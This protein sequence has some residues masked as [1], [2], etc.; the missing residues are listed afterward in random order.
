MSL[1]PR[2]YLR[3]ILAEANYLLQA[4]RDVTYEEFIGNG[5]LVRA[6]SR[7]IEIMGEAA[8]SVPADIIAAHPEIEWSGMARMRDRLIHGYF[9]VDER[10]VWAVV[11][12]KVPDLKQNLE[13]I[14]ADEDGG[15]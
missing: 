3:H 9:S 11:Q 14:L 12:E 1:E 15:T 7:S 2:E 4:S 5:T 6:F 8:K 10:F 13:A